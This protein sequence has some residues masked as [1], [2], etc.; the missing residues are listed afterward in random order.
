MKVKIGSEGRGSWGLYYIIKAIRK[1]YKDC[2]ILIPPGY[3]GNHV[4]LISK[5]DNVV[6]CE[7]SQDCDFIVKSFFE[8]EEPLWNKNSKKYIYW[9]GESC[10]PQRSEY[11]TDYL[12]LLTIKDQDPKSAYMP[13][14]MYSPHV[15][16]GKIFNRHK[17][18][19]VAYCSRNCVPERE[20]LFNFLVENSSSD[21]CSSLGECCGKYQNTSCKLPGYWFDEKLLEKYAEHQ[22]VISMENKIFEGYITEKILNAFASGSI[23]IFWG[24]SATCKKIFNKDSFVDVSDFD[25]IES[26]AKYVSLMSQDEIS[27]KES[28]DIFNKID[29]ID[30]RQVLIEESTDKINNF[31]FG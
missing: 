8:N 12:N 3:S 29:G 30:S 28:Q 6:V 21:M 11:E 19:L 1:K 9:S 26:C 18:K 14:F 15:N 31:L 22:F 5:F 2:E 10:K 27:H 20:S 25:S 7:N 24:D 17:E 23:P 4:D 16:A 13:F